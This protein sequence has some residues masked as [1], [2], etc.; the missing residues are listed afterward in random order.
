MKSLLNVEIHKHDHEVSMTGLRNRSIDDKKYNNYICI[1]DFIQQTYNKKLLSYS[2]HSHPTP[3]YYQFIINEIL[4]KLNIDSIDLLN[5]DFIH[6]GSSNFVSPTQFRFF[7][8]IFPNLQPLSDIE[9]KQFSEFN[10]NDLKIFVDDGIKYVNELIIS[11]DK[12]TY[13]QHIEVI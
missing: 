6:G 13:I 11:E 1:Y 5:F 12:C 10:L 4:K 9:I 7:N 3:T 8:D 2:H